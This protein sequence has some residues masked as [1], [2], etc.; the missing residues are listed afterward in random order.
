M[1]H[2][3]FISYAAEDIEA[4]KAICSAIE[5]H[6]IRCWYAK[7]DVVVGKV[8]FE[9]VPPVIDSSTVMFFIS[10]YHSNRS[11]PVKREIER[12]SGKGIPIITIRID[13]EP[14]EP[15]LE[16]LIGV[17]QW[18]DAQE[19]P[20]SAHMPQLI[21]TIRQIINQQK[22]VD[23][24]A[25][26][27]RKTI[28]YAKIA[29]EA[30][31]V[32]E[33]AIQ[34]KEKERKNVIKKGLSRKTKG[35]LIGTTS[36]AL[37]VVIVILLKF[38]IFGTN[39]DTTGPTVTNTPINTLTTQS[40]V[41]SNITTSSATTTQPTTATTTPPPTSVATPEEYV[42]I[43]F[44]PT[45]FDPSE[46]FGNE[47]FNIT[48]TGNFTC[49]KDIPYAV[50]GLTIKP[51]FNASHTTEGGEITLISSGNI[52]ATSIPLKQGETVSFVQTIPAHFPDNV[53]DGYYNLFFNAEKI[54]V[55]IGLWVDI[56]EF[57]QLK[58]QLISWI[59]Y[60]Q[61]RPTTSTINNSSIYTVSL[62]PIT[63]IT[64]EQK[65]LTRLLLQQLQITLSW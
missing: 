42:A 29:G 58:K 54:K 7:R 5:S 30:V 46:V 8:W 57:F 9:T 22:E 38:T 34:I 39:V 60:A 11:A 4:A 20:L 17:R 23:K 24:K 15:S 36:V 13:Y 63:I 44:G 48:I 59:Q 21:E 56:D 43:S 47:T 61:H 10:S 25:A 33:A 16:F 27:A 18:L 12:A 49:L 19:P 45:S 53:K 3:V 28:D 35:I 26:E 55:N 50:S 14:V 31:K 32:G 2:D 64:D 52:T 65:R 37:V 51:I 62:S 6:N 1:A 41:G 40:G